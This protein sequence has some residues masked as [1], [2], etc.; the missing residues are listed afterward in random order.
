MYTT[1]QKLALFNHIVHLGVTNASCSKRNYEPAGILSPHVY[2]V[3]YPIENPTNIY[4]MAYLAYLSMHMYY[5]IDF[6]VFWAYIGVIMLVIA[7]RLQV[8]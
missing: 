2:I 3:L 7:K 8:F 6:V 1:H 4:E 5:I